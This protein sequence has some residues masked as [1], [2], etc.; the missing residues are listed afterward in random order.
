ME[1]VILKFV[2]IAF[3]VYVYHYQLLKSSEEF[4]VAKS[5]IDKKTFDRI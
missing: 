3:S 5:V 1:T 2:N 4:N